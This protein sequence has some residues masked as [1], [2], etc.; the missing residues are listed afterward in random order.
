MQGCTEPRTV[1]PPLL[2]ALPPSFPLSA[3]S[4]SPSLSPSHT[5]SLA[6]SLPP[7]LP[8]SLTLRPPRP[9]LAP[10][11][12]PPRSTLCASCFSAAT[13]ASAVPPQ[14]PRP[15]A[16]S[17]PARS[18]AVGREAGSAAVSLPVVRR[19]GALAAPRPASEPAPDTLAEAAGC[20]LV[21][22]EA[23]AASRPHRPM[24]RRRRLR[25]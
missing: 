21:R 23:A 11:L 1:F 15:L 20:I 18:A 5:R 8:L 14:P 24:R 16:A 3:P 22:L 7:F 2:F 9:R 13:T 4:L 25:A 19:G 12:P 17:S 6:P 10:S